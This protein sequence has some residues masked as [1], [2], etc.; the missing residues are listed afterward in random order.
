MSN[1]QLKMS[2]FPIFTPFELDVPQF[3]IGPEHVEILSAAT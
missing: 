3:V 1:I 2:D